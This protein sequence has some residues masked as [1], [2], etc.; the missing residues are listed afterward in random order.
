LSVV[1]RNGEIEISVEDDG[2][3]FDPDAEHSGFGLPGMRERVAMAGGRFELSASPGA[4]AKM[5][6]VI[7][8]TASP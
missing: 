7:P 3:G 5:R 2:V 6:A 1:E 4:G 8:T